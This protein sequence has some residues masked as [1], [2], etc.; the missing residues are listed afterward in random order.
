LLGVERCIPC[1]YG[2]WP[3]LTGTPEELRELASGV[4]IEE[5]EPGG[6]LTV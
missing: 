6:S 5:M 3:I 2:T 4:Q 1:H